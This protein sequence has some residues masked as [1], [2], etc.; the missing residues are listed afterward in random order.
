[1]T[2]DEQ[3]NQYAA[4]NKAAVDRLRASMRRSQRLMMAASILMLLNAIGFMVALVIGL[5]HR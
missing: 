3:L 5:V 2:P 1:M 4:D